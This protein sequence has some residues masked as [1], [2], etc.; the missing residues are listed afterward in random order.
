[1]KLVS[2]FMNEGFAK[3]ASRF[4]CVVCYIIMIV[5]IICFVLSCMGRQSFSLHTDSGYYEN[6]IYAEE[7]HDPDFRM[8]TVNMVGDEIHVHSSDGQIEGKIQV[9]LS[10]MYAVTIVP[11][12]LG[13]WFLS[14][15]FTNVSNGQIFT[16]KNAVY[17]LYYG[18][19]QFITALLVPF[20]KLFI[21]FLIN[22]ISSDQISIS[23]GSN[24][25]NNLI[26]SIGF[27]VAAY[28]IHYGI[29][30]QDEVDHTL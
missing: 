17:L 1:M 21:C 20:I 13:F 2:K 9:G 25:L 16:E 6:A 29:H 3:S 5:C 30:L 22:S 15:V 4:M 26:P 18:V 12:I 23:T 11:A 27:L 14:R 10:L 28:I 19:I 24:I 7:N 8:P